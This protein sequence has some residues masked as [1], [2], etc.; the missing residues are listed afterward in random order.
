METHRFLCYLPILSFESDIVYASDYHEARRIY[1]AKRKVP[2]EYANRVVSRQ[3]KPLD[4]TISTS[5][6]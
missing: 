3:M 5:V 6:Q 1:I 4:R 2:A